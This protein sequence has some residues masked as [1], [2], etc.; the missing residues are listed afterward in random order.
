MVA[1]CGYNVFH[2]EYEG[3]IPDLLKGLGRNFYRRPLA[4]HN[5]LWRKVFSVADNIAAQL[6]IAD[7][8][9]RLADHHVQW[10]S[11]L[12]VQVAD[13]LLADI[14]LRSQGHVFFPQRVKN[15]FHTTNITNLY[16]KWSDVFLL[17][18][19]IKGVNFEVW[20]RR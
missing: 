20:H 10:P 4:F 19:W 6:D 14:L 15:L 16:V 5:H 18:D 8:D 12:L 9:F 13:K 3:V 2:L 11:P 7:G 1:V 17:E